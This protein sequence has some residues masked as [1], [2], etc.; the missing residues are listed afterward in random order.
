MDELRLCSDDL[1][2]RCDPS[3]FEFASTEELPPLEGIIGQERAMTAIDFGIGIRSRG[4][5]LF[6]L[7]Q[8]GTGR[9]ST[10]KA[11]LASHAENQPVPDD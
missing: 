10:I 8:P 4:F 1:C 3:Q 2:W 11:H 6:I 5:N 7:G 9:T